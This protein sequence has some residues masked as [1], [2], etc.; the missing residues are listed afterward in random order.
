LFREAIARAQEF[1]FPLFERRCMA[2]FQQFL[3]SS[4][5]RDP[6]IDSRLIELAYLEN[7]G[8]RVASAVRTI[9]PV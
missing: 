5:R 2:S 3:K 6:A 7:L 4:G 1:G 8:D 9:S